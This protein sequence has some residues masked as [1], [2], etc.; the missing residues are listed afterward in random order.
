MLVHRK[1]DRSIK[2]FNTPLQ[3]T[4][5]HTPQLTTHTPSLFIHTHTHHPSTAHPPSPPRLTVPRSARRCGGPM[6]SPRREESCWERTTLSRTGRVGPAA[7]APC[8][9]PTCSTSTSCL[10]RWVMS[11]FRVSNRQVKASVFLSHGDPV[12]VFDNHSQECS[13][14]IHSG[15]RYT[16]N[17]YCRC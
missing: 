3:Y 10:D 15:N 5:T 12:F 4:H 9:P 16:E 13:T 14:D 7:K 2:P 1:D 8:Q 11:S 17:H 6:G